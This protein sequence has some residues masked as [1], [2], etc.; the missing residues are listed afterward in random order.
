[1]MD[2][3]PHPV[4]ERDAP[5]NAMRMIRDRVRSRR[6]GSIWRSALAVVGIWMFGLTVV[7]AGEPEAIVEIPIRIP[8]GPLFAEV[9][10]L[11]P[12]EV[13]RDHEWRDY[14]G[15]KVRYAARRGPLEIY[16]RGDTLFVRATVAYWLEARKPILGRLSVKGSCGIDEPPRA[17]VLS[18]AVR[19]TVE[20]NWQ[21]AAQLAVMPP[22]FL[23]PCEMTAVGIDVTEIVGR[24]L[25]EQLW[26]AVEQEMAAAVAA[27]GDGRAR[28]A[29]QW[30]R[31]Q[32]PLGVDENTWLLLSPEAVWT[33]HPVADGRELSLTVG[34]A[35]RLR[36][37]SG[38]VAPTVQATPLPPL[39]VAAPR[40]P[41][42]QLPFQLTVTYADAAALLATRLAGQRFAWAGKSV[43]VEE[44]RLTP[45]S[46]TVTVE[47]VVSGDLVGTV[48]LTGRPA[49]DAETRELYLA[50]LDYQLETE[51]QR[52]RDLD[53]GLHD[54]IRGTIAARARWPLAERIAAFQERAEQAINGALPSR[55]RV[56]TSLGDVALTDIRLNE[57]AIFVQGAVGGTAQV[58][59]D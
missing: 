41:L 45:G 24:V 18:L 32:A 48:K 25:H 39:G 6:Y 53:R 57:N 13:R 5:P 21:L 40:P 31:L 50:G 26:R 54:L 49:F 9:E 16:A 33:T 23:A 15:V 3:A 36:L 44:A 10:R 11:V 8:L 29:D 4:T 42:T 34:L 55:F 58:L 30:R 7:E 51:D 47:A 35:S 56:R 22:A 43:R 12:T 20:P 52:V 27:V 59:V 2:P 19:L 17:V 14:K 28:A 37:V 38:P 1:M 46:E